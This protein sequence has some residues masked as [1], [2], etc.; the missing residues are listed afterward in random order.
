MQS[1]TTM[2]LLENGMEWNEMNWIKIKASIK[3]TLVYL[4]W[5]WFTFT[6]NSTLPDQLQLKLIKLILLYLPSFLTQFFF[7]LGDYAS[8]FF[9]L[10]GTKRLM[11]WSR[12]G[13]FIRKKPPLFLPPSFLTFVTVPKCYMS[14]V[15]NNHE[16]ICLE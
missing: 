11:L 4:I 9:F 8:S 1:N 14:L 2:F 6:N 16:G 15:D 5:Y 7:L 13:I 10:I 12:Q 3:H